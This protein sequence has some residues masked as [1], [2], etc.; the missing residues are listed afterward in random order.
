MAAVR[1]RGAGG[2]SPQSRALAVV[3]LVAVAALALRARQGL[4]WGRLAEPVEVRWA[5]V[6]LGST[7]LTVLI[8]TTRRLL[9]RLRKVGTVRPGLG[10][11]AEPEG[12]PF[13]FLLRVAGAVLVLAGAAVAWWIIRSIEPPPPDALGSATKNPQ[14]QHGGPASPLDSATLWTVLLLVGVGLLVTSIVSRRLEARRVE[15]DVDEEADHRV[16]VQELVAAVDAAEGELARHADPREAVLAAYR[17]MA[18][19]LSRG[20]ARR[21]AT[22]RGSDTATELLDQA[23]AAGLVTGP[24]ARTLTDLFREARFSRHPMGPEARR[25][26]ERCLAQVRQELAAHRA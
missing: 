1:G 3:A 5:R 14:G 23:V 9:R 12:E 26:A 24:P 2:Q 17:A 7:I 19:H 13:P 15:E 11:R 6:L 21:G 8:V 4:D 10:E 20:L 22:A 16:E 25:S 18:R